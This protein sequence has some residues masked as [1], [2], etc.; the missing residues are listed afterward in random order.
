[1][2]LSARRER[3]DYIPPEP[4]IQEPESP[5]RESEPAYE[6]RQIPSGNAVSLKAILEAL[7]VAA[8]SLL[9]V[10]LANYVPIASIVGIIL[11][12]VPTAILV[13]RRGF[14]TGLIAL[15]V[16]SVSCY[17][18]FDLNLTLQVIG[19]YC[20]I[21]FFLGYCFRSFKGP[22]FTLGISTPPPPL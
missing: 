12:P 2:P 7:A 18:L 9:L 17:S 21:G 19:Q 1:M 11:L 10:Y 13:F 4:P 16:L 8:L 22:L 3:A 6:Y 20:T 14:I 15:I 5:A